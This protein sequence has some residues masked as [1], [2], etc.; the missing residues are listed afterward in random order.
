MLRPSRQEYYTP[1][2]DNIKDRLADDAMIY[3]D[4]SINFVHLTNTLQFL[5]PIRI[6]VTKSKVLNDHLTCGNKN[7]N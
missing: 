5:Q 6:F 2:I 4:T 1:S 7:I 3:N